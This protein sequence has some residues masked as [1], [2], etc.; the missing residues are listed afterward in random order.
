M[1]DTNELTLILLKPDA[2]RRNL[3][4]EIEGMFLRDGL[5]ILRRAW[6]ETVPRELI[7]EHYAEHRDRPYFGPTVEFMTSG[8]LVALVIV[9]LDAIQRSRNLIGHRDPKVAREQNPRSIR[10]VY[11]EKVE[12]NLVHGSDSKASAQREIELWFPTPP[13][14]FEQQQILL[15]SGHG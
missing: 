10:A 3:T 2:V 4:A 8:P 7:E 13:M 5:G 1:A 14:S 6:Y 9:G 12:E 11:G 15:Q